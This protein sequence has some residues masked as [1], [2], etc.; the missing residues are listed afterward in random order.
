MPL[1]KKMKAPPGCPHLLKDHRGDERGSGMVGGSTARLTG[2]NRPPQNNYTATGLLLFCSGRGLRFQRRGR[3]C[4]VLGL[5]RR[6]SGPSK[7]G[8]YIRLN[9]MRVD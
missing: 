9:P 5:S 2:P 3:A 8:P 1:P 7:L 6:N 4:P